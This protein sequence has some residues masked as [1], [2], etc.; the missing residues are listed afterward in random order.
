MFHIAKP[1]SSH[2]LLA[3]SRAC[4]LACSS[5]SS[6]LG[7]PPGVLSPATSQVIPP[8]HV[9]PEP[10]YP[11]GLALAITATPP[12]ETF[13]RTAVTKWLPPWLKL[14][15]ARAWSPASHLAPIQNSPLE[16][17]RPPHLNVSFHQISVFTPLFTPLSGVLQSIQRPP[18]TLWS[19]VPSYEPSIPSQTPWTDPRF[20]C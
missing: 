7:A 19:A 10:S 12:F 13:S 2:R 11:C 14:R 15:L 16:S 3:R 18:G 20:R 8:R 9:I 17:L 1:A 6:S 4:F 5:A